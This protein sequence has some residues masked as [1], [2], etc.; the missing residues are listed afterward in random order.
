MSNAP[1]HQREA[2]DSQQRSSGFSGR[3]LDRRVVLRAAAGVAAIAASG[4]IGGSTST[5]IAQDDRERVT[6]ASD[7]EPPSAQLRTASVGGEGGWQEF[8]TDFPFYAI[9]ASWPVDVGDWPQ[10]ELKL[11]NNGENWSE[12]YFLTADNDGGGGTDASAERRFTPLLHTDGSQFVQFRTLDADGNAALVSGLRFTYIDA[13][14]GPW[15]KDIVDE[16]V[17]GEIGIQ[18]VDTTTPPPIVTRAGWGAN[19]SYRFASFGEIWPPEYATVEHVI[20]HHTA[21]PNSQD[22]P[23]AVR[24]IYY[25][26]AVTQGWGDIGYNYLVGRDGRIYQG[27]VGGQNV[28][29]GH[30]YQY[31]IGSSG[32][33]IIGDFQSTP[34]PQDALAGL[35]SIVAWVGRDLDPHGFSDFHETL[36][37]PTICSHRDVSATTCPGDYLYNQL[38]Q[39]R[40]LV[41][42]TLASGDLETPFPGGIV[43][44][45]RVMV[46]TSGESLNLRSGAGTSYE[47]SGSLPSGAFA[48]VVDGPVETDEGNWLLLDAEDSDL[49][50]W[51]VADYL[52][53]TPF[54][55]D[56]SGLSY[57][58]NIYASETVRIRSGPSL[59]SGIV[60]SAVRGD[61]G[62]IMA[63]PETADGYDWY[64]V[65][66]ENGTEGWTAVNYIGISP[67]DENPPAKFSVGDWVIATESLSIRVRPGVAQTIIASLAAGG[68]LQI[69]REAFGVNNHVWYGVYTEQDDGGWVVEDVLRERGGPSEA[70]F[71]IGD[72]IRVTENLSLR[73][74][75]GTSAGR[76]AVMP[77]G[78]TGTVVAGPDTGSGYTWWQIETSAYGT[79]WAVQD[80]MEETDDGGTTPPPTGRFEVGDAVRT[81]DGNLRLRTGAS[82]SSGVIAMLPAGTTGTVVGGP[83]TGSGYTWW[84]I[85]TSYGTGW[86]AEDWLAEDDGGSTPPPPT[87]RFE[88]GDA[89]RVTENLNMRTGASTGSG[90]IAVLPAGTTGTVVGGPQSGSGYTWW[91]IETSYGT[92]WVV[93]NWLTEDGGGSPP[94]TG[95]FQAGDRVRTTANLYMRSGPSTSNSVVSLLPSGTTGTVVDGPQTGSG[96][97]WWRIETSSGT[98]WSVEDWLVNA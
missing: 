91:R 32:I 42:A 27:R 67:V 30:S 23:T 71:E 41:A 39:I 36:G 19:E 60:S 62:F 5:A 33:S 38:P 13:T 50:G 61:L 75:P 82:T 48:V 15:E 14:D 72:T 8:Q 16:G 20:V 3:E 46:N 49:T 96:Y 54:I 64:Q 86:A 53:V 73:T 74:G 35:V 77:A 65:H 21:T 93:E 59:S 58:T 83:Q 88:N 26:H 44:G 55:I 92:G 4:G 11:S 34:V 68:S 10:I 1:H 47:V 51:A 56:A 12:S 9:G 89:V 29:G 7:W 24:S 76:I 57:G 79:G 80:W 52:L 90:V 63:G 70:K 18:S 98:G 22:I 66:W 31:A 25:Y 85:E 97:T 40:D 78:T 84:R 2:E 94:P 28:I 69:T 6:R 87:G 43:V 45:D 17:G 95:R 37:L 81:T